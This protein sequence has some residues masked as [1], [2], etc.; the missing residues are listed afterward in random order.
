MPL[1][2][3]DKVTHMF[4]RRR[5]I[6]SAPRTFSLALGG[7][8]AALAVVGGGTVVAVSGPTDVVAGDI[9]LAQSAPAHEM[10][11]GTP[12]DLDL[13]AVVANAAGGTIPEGTTV[14]V[15]GLPDGLVQNGW[16]ISGTPTR[17]G[18]YDVLITVTSSG[19][20]RSERVTIVVT[21]DGPGAGTAA[22]SDEASPNPEA[23]TEAGEPDPTLSAVPGHGA[24][25]D[26]QGDQVGDGVDEGEA[27]SPDLCAI[28]GDEGDGGMDATALA[29]S[30]APM[31]AGDDGAGAGESGQAGMVLNAIVGLLPSLLGETGSVAD[32]GSAG[33]LLCA[34]PPSLLGGGGVDTTVPTDD[35]AEAAGTDAPGAAPLTAG[36]AAEGGLGAPAATAAGLSGLPAALVGLLGADTGSLGD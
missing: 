13:E 16:V 8:L 27:V 10:E 33:Q 2:P 1:L 35:E 11:L 32:A 30:L 18:E 23:T 20:S 14:Q 19:Q 31:L 22:E 34:L 5:P 28:V 17:A 7:A 21:E 36:G 15:T 3:D 26:G 24:A 4:Q 9:L 12:V 29:A 6:R 25:A